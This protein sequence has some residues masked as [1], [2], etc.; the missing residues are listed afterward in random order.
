MTVQVCTIVA[1]NYLPRA[2]VLA[3]SVR[4]HHPL[5]RVSVLVIDDVYA[6]VD[7]AEEPFEVVRPADIGLA[8]DEFHRMAM[9]YDIVE[10]AT[11]LKPWLLQHLLDRDGAAP[12]I[13]L[14]PDVRV[15]DRLDEVL[16]F[17][18]AH[19]IVLTP[20]VTAPIPRD[21]KMTDENTI[22]SAG[23]YNLGFIAVSRQA[24]PFLRFWMERLRRDCTVDPANN[25]FVDQ[26]WVDFVPS[27]F[28]CHILREPSY[29][30][31]YWNLDHR[32]LRWGA[33]GYRVDGQPLRFFHYRG[34]DAV[35]PSLLSRWQGERPR[36]LLTEHPDLARICA[37]YAGQHPSRRGRCPLRPSRAAQRRADPGG[38]A[39]A[40]PRPSGCGRARRPGRAS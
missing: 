16:R 1:R 38:A 40:V 17:A 32:E 31:A 7:G 15:Y 4:E 26:R 2:R 27:L 35:V 9:I 23:M 11:S 19:G 20:H 28:D 22:L 34:F 30:V 13:Y 5:G 39:P 10:L 29:N 33:D 12:A 24:Q 8:A 6:E 21:G 3:T 14:D 18:A 36:I 37:D 25:R